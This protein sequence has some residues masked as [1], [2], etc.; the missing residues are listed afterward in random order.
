[1]GLWDSIRQVF[2][3][4]P[5]SSGGAWIEMERTLRDN[6]REFYADLV[7]DVLRE[8]GLRGKLTDPL[9]VEGSPCQWGR[10]PQE[11]RAAVM[12]TLMAMSPG[13]ISEL[14]AMQGGDS[15]VFGDFSAFPGTQQN[16]ELEQAMQEKRLKFITG[17]TQRGVRVVGVVV[18]E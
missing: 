15:G 4:R 10:T 7:A 17:R 3:P 14:K 11:Y 12:K 5:Q 8:R 16:T 6:Y 13:N 2:G 1:M 9:L 18:L